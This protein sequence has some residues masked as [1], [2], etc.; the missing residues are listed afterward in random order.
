MGAVKQNFK[1]RSCLDTDSTKATLAGSIGGDLQGR[2]LLGKKQE[3]WWRRVGFLD[4]QKMREGGEDMEEFGDC[5]TC[6]W[7]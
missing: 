1:Q 2:L 5:F 4:S 7:Q 6:A 3:P